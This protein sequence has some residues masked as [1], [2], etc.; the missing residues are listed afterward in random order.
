MT[1]TPETP[2]EATEPVAETVT[3]PVDYVVPNGPAL[4]GIAPPNVSQNTAGIQEVPLSRPDSS[5]Q[6]S[7]SDILAVVNRIW[8][9]L[10][11][12]Q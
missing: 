4:M 11:S 7:L 8:E 10:T 12:T 3:E 5:P 2:V 6:P 1:E 9:H